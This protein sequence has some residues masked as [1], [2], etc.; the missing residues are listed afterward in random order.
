MS[1]LTPPTESWSWADQISTYRFWGLL[2]FYAFSGVLARVVF[3]FELVEAVFSAYSGTLAVGYAELIFSIG[4]L[5]GVLLAWAWVSSDW[6]PKKALLFF[7]LLQLIGL[8]FLGLGSF[9]GTWFYVAAFVFGLGLGAVLLG[10]PAVIAGGRGGF[11]T[12][13]LVFGSFLIVGNF[14]RL[15]APA[16]GGLII[17]TFGLRGSVALTGSILL[18]GLLLLIPANPVFFDEPPPL[19]SHSFAPRRRSPIIVALLGFVPLY[20]FYWLY[21]IHGEVAHLAPS[22]S[23]LSPRAA[24]WTAFVPFL[25]LVSMA[26]LINQLNFRASQLGKPPYSSPLAMFFWSLIFFPLGMALIQSAINGLNESS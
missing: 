4:A 14:L 23:L 11:T 7:G 6:A 5:L 1:T 9:S 3:Q 22:R 13:V 10:V 26:T 19:R 15:V 8:V 17:A 12:F 21:L 25:S 20:S 16:I 24:V 18:L 2:A